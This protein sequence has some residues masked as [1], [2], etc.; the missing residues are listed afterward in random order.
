MQSDKD[1]EFERQG[2]SR[3]P[4]DGLCGWLVHI[5]CFTPRLKKKSHTDLH[6]P[7]F[8]Q[9]QAHEPPS[10]LHSQLR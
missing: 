5:S 9:P 8:L 10:P 2:Q 3:E 1:T 4:R 6:A 7:S